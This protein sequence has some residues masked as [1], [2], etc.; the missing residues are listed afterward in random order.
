MFGQDVEVRARVEDLRAFSAH[1]DRDDLLRWAGSLETTP[2]RT[3]VVHGEPVAA[4]ALRDRLDEQ[5]GH[6]AAVAEL[7]GVVRLT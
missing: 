2:R 3:F 7:D 1:G 5:L 6:D 4:A